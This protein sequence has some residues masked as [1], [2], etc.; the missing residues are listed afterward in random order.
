MKTIDT[1]RFV[2]DALYGQRLRSTLSVLGIAIGVAAVVLLT[3]L[4][5]GVK[6]YIVSQFTQFGTSLIAI[7]PG[8]IKTF[9]IPGVFGGTTRQLTIADAVALKKAPGVNG[10]IPLVFG[11]ARVSAGQRGRN[12]YVYGV[13]H[14]ASAVWKFPVSQ[15]SFLPDAGPNRQGAYAVLGPKLAREIMGEKSPLGRRIRIGGRGFIVVGVMEPKGEFM[16]FDLDDSA[17]IPVAS[18]MALF[19]VTELNEIDV[20]A[21]SQEAVSSTAKAV[22]SVLKA[23]HGGNVDFTV[24]TQAQMLKTFGRIINVVTMAVSAIAGIS[25]F[26]GAIGILTIMWISV[27]ERT[28]EIGL[29]RALGLTKKGVEHLFLAEAGFL[30]SLGGLAGLA[31]GYGLGTLLTWTVPGLPMSTPPEAAVAALLMS[32]VVGLASGWL[33]ARKAAALDPIESLRAE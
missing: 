31:A 15:G 32:F 12:V 21:P 4:G 17:Y 3:S 1:V 23:R 18:G 28:G 5:Q 19:N 6:E 20:L 25:L 33:P 7:N 2:A 13:G 30:A 29:L 24:T 11:E 27:N 22:T 16:G 9:G 26:V 10:V 14:Q 8:K